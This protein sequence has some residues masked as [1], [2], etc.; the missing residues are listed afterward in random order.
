MFWKSLG[1]Q[2]IYKIHTHK[3]TKFEE[4]VPMHSRD[5]ELKII[6]AVTAK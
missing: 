5:I 4:I 6:K 1:Y 2:N 3:H